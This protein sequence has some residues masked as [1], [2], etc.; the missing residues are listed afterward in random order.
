M[1]SR[2]PPRSHTAIK[3]KGRGL[4]ENIKNKNKNKNKTKA[5]YQPIETRAGQLSGPVPHRASST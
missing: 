5:G 3:E 1:L 4:A 2:P